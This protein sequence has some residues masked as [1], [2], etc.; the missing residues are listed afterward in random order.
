MLAGFREVVVVDFEFAA[1]PGER[2]APV[3][4]VAYELR[5][6]R[7]FR[8]WQDQ[9]GPTPPYAHGPDV[10]FVAYF[11]SADLGCYRMLGW[12][13]PERIL[14][15]YVEFRNLTNGLHKPA[16]AGLLG[17]L[18]YFGLDAMD[19]VEKKEIQE[20]IGSGTWEGKHTPKEIMDY[21]EQDGA[22]LA[23]LL[24]RMLPRI[25][26]PRALL[27]GRSIA[28]V[29]AI[30]HAGTPVDVEMLALLRDGW[31]GIQDALIAAVDVDYGVYEGRTFK[32]ERF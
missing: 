9:F 21:C 7:R 26:L 30:E 20:A 32:A 28:A 10:L 15:P 17:A 31:T 5:S 29:S 12:P 18:V 13:M 1:L 27:R 8:I 3:C 24:P 23:R 11:S 14:D 22:A 2:P 19:A 16:G 4:L 6:G 25:D